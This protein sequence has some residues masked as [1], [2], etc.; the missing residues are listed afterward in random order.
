ML[1][2]FS[3]SFHYLLLQIFS[4]DAQSERGQDDK[5]RREQQSDQDFAQLGI[6]AIRSGSGQ[7][8]ED[9]DD[10][11]HDRGADKYLRGDFLHMII[12]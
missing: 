4:R 9:A 6:G 12:G 3:P 11:E 7:N 8:D 1:N 2:L 5:H 10:A